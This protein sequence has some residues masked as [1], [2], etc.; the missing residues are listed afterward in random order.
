M[1]ICFECSEYPPGPH[2]GIGSLVQIMARGLAGAGHQVRVAGLYPSSYPAPDYEEDG[3]IRVWR[4]RLPASRWGWIG[5][6]I[7]LYRLVKSWCEAG[8]V[9]L[10]EVPDYGAPAAYWPSLPVPVVAR[11]S[12]STTFFRSEMGR[13]PGRT[14][15]L[16]ERASLRRADFIL[17]ESRYLEERTRA[18]F[19]LGGAPGEVI[20][21]PVDMPAPAPPVVRDRNAVM[22]AGTLTE[23]K[24][25]ISLVRSWPGVVRAFP[26]AVLHVWGKDGQAPAGGSMQSYLAT[27]V[28]AEV[29]ASVV[30]HGHV[31]LDTLL[32]AF[33]TAGMAVLP[34]Y[35]EGFALTPLHAMAAGCPVVYTSR[36]SG[37]ELIRDRVTGLL[38]DPDRPEEIGAAIRA[39]LGD[40]QMA[41]RIGEAGRQHVERN[42]A[43]PVLLA[44]NE[45]F[46]KRCLDRFGAD[47][48]THSKDHGNAD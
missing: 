32:G 10:V 13:R 48:H 5:A 46:Y 33:R 24:G 38:V 11:L 15:K 18:V 1:K 27:L 19:A 41:S 23:K 47:R 45:Q 4:L 44:Q 31:P 21:N 40:A 14:A 35:A 29:S 34:S 43:R 8:E 6:R 12:G 2:G 36:G 22:F 3:G 7:R 42:F 26:G 37:P 28:P 16:L 39:L 20:Y 9:D 30:F 25:V 17:S